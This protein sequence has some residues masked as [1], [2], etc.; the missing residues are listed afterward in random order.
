MNKFLV[1]FL[2]IPISLFSQ[3]EVD[4]KVRKRSQRSVPSYSSPSE[5]NTVFIPNNQPTVIYPYNNFYNPYNPYI[6]YNVNR[7]RYYG[8]DYYNGHSG[9]RKPS[10]FDTRLG[11]VGGLSTPSSIGLYGTIGRDNFIYLSYE[12]SKISEYE[13]YDNISYE[14]VVSWND[15]YVGDF[16]RYTSFTVAIGNELFENV[17]HYAGVNLS[18]VDKDLVFFDELFILSNNGEYSINDTTK[19]DF[20]L[21]YGLL[22]DIKK[23]S[24]GPS[25]YFLGNTRINLN[26]GFNF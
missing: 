7:S 16:E 17:S 20:G 10:N 5:G 1:L 6:P 12:G 26:L 4:E 19:R 23:F 3:N 22:F 9:Y 15:T 14:D 21:V 18:K 24:V 13:H 11:L 8:N 2:L 25:V